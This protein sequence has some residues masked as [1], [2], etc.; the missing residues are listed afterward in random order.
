[1][2]LMKKLGLLIVVVLLLTACG[3][4]ST[5]VDVVE[6]SGSSAEDIEAGREQ[7]RV[8]YADN[9]LSPAL[10]LAV[11]TLLL[12]ETDLA[13]DADQAA[14][15]VPYWKLYVTLTESDTTAPE[16]LNALINEIQ[17]LMTPDQVSYIAGLELIQEDLMTLINE[18]GIFED[19]RADGSGD[20]SGA[21]RPEGMP[22]GVRPG[23]GQGGGRGAEGM[24]PELVATMQAQRE[25]DG[26]GSFR[27]NRFIIPLVEE[28]ISLLEE[29]AG[30]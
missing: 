3:S 18:L 28:L 23:G 13:V 8:D 21:S 5:G 10:Q 16:E 2:N 9:A 6:N 30:S 17:I 19:L 12:E 14:T 22:E 26:G 11:G 29:K 4:E 20:G 25:E 1:M 24:D 27:N 15:L 7:L